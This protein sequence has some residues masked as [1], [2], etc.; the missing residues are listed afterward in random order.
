MR[1]LFAGTVLCSVLALASP[2]LF[3]GGEPV[4]QFR[5]SQAVFQQSTFRNH[6]LGVRSGGYIMAASRAAATQIKAGFGGL[7][8]NPAA[9]AF[10]K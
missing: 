5:N 9:S 3:G 8:L 1:T 10:R 6:C 2:P 7:R 4:R